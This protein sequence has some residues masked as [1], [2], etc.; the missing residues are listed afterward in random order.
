[1]AKE[2]KPNFIYIKSDLLK[3][4]VAVSKKTG[5]VICEDGV[6]YGPQEVKIIADAGGVLDM[7]MHRIK[8]ILGGEVV[9]I[10]RT[11][12]KSKPD[13]R[14]SG[15]NEHNNSSAADKVSGVNGVSA[16]NREGELDI[17]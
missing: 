2:Y 1:M 14:T 16:Q 3:Q 15:K 7:A 8:K 4:E 6:T 5:K 9:K 12:N 17:Y 10:E 11:G 13:E